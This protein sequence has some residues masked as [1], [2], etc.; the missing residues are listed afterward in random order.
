MIDIAANLTLVKQIIH[1]NEARYHRAKNSVQLLAVSKGQPVEKIRE[2]YDAGQR[3]F[4][5]N[6][7]QEALPK[8]HALADTKIEWHYVGPIQ[9]NKTKKIA[10]QFS[11][12][13]SVSDVTTA[14]RLSEQR[15]EN[16][17]SLNIC[18]QV[19]ISHEKSK[20]GMPLHTVL[21]IAEQCDALPRLKLRGLMTIIGVS[22]DLNEQ[23]QEF[24]QL[25]QYQ[26]KLSEKGIIIDTLSMG[27]SDDMEA[28]IA[29]GSTLVRVGSKIFGAR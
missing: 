8:I 2:A 20:S 21:S 7:L 28:A 17:P 16:L 22:S 26:H 4:G 23:R 6:Y 24:N 11:W 15:P 19:N 13:H 12:V 10:E 18:L 3:M 29:E 1:E 9:S 27:M 14:Q 25:A 5:E